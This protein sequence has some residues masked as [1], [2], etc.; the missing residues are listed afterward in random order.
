MWESTV[1]KLTD[2]VDPGFVREFAEST[3]AS[4]FRWN[5]GNHGAG[6]PEGPSSGLEGYVRGTLGGRFFRRTQQNRC[7]YSDHLG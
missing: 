6:E 7:P 4:G 5:H 1:S 3:L 2:P